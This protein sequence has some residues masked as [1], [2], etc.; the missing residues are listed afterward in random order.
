MARTILIDTPDY[1]KTDRRLMAKDL[2]ELY[3]LWDNLSWWK[4]PD[5]KRK[6]DI[7][8][9]TNVLKPVTSLIIAYETRPVSP[10]EAIIEESQGSA[11]SQ[12]VH[13]TDPAAK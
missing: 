3:W 1:S 2:E 5:H 11:I 10:V 8:A 9:D 6:P 13:L 7:V 12:L 4:T